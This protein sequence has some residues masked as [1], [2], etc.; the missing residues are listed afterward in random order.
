MKP[1]IR[2]ALLLVALTVLAPTLG[3]A[4]AAGARPPDPGHGFDKTPR[5]AI[6]SAFAPELEALKAQA[7]IE[8]VVVLNGRSV[9]VGTLARHK[10]LLTLSGVSMVNAAMTTQALIDH[11][12]VEGILFSGIA[13]GVDPGLN[14]GDVVI[15]ARWSEYQENLFARETAPGVFTPPSWFQ[16]TLPNY[17]MMFPEDV[18]IC[19]VDG[20]P[21]QE[22]PVVWFP[23]DSAMLKAATRVAGTVVLD[24]CTSQNV[25]L[26]T[27]P[28]VRPGGSG[29]SG[30]TFVDNAGYRDYARGVW[31]ADALDMESAALAHVATVN[32]VPFIILRSLSDL[33]GGGPGENEMDTFFQLA[34]NN[35][36]RVMMAFLKAWPKR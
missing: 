22:S 13:G 17:G 28:V 7:N 16:V 25:C 31:Q 27:T 19:T 36:A 34:A 1:R 5:L 29:V 8:K 26:D 33:A 35:S 21:D 30:P 20:T 3:G 15:P 18:D 24:R 10:V 11:F 12:R 23:V 2:L 4:A 14:I 6:I 9:Y 32:G